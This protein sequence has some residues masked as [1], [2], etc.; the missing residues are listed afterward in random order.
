LVPENVIAW[1][2]FM[3]FKAGLITRQMTGKNVYWGVDFKTME[4]AFRLHRIPE[5]EQPDMLRKITACIEEAV[6]EEVRAQG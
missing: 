6:E 1:H 5:S 3:Q 2:M 4:F